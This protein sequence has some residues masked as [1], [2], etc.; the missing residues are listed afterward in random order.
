MH[1]KNDFT[2]VCISQ[3]TFEY[4]PNTYVLEKYEKFLVWSICN[5]ILRFKCIKISFVSQRKNILWVI[6]I[7]KKKT[8]CKHKV[9]F[10]AYK[11]CIYEYLCQSK[12]I[13]ISFAGQ[14]R[15]ILRSV[16]IYRHIIDLG[17]YKN[18]F[19]EIF[20]TQNV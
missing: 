9:A 17:A 18:D 2:D 4:K 10:G 8:S 7:Y 11:R 14:R 6:F 5:V 3:G 16:R 1:T 13:K 15:N 20:I 19:M 12:C